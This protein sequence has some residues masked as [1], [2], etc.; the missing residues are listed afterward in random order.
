LLTDVIRK[1]GGTAHTPCGGKGVCR[2]CRVEVINEA[3]VLSCQY[4]VT[5][6]CHVVIP[7][8][9]PDTAVVQ[10]ESAILKDIAPDKTYI[11]SGLYGL[12]IDIG[13]TTVVVYLIELATGK[14]VDTF[15]FLNPQSEFGLDVI[16][17]I[18]YT[19]ENSDGLKT[20]QSRIVNAINTGIDQLSKRNSIP[21][22][23]IV[24][25]VIA[26]NTTMLHLLAGI[27][28]KGIAFAPFTPAFIEEKIIPAADIGIKTAS[29]SNIIL[30]PS[31][32]AYV[33][34]DITSGIAVTPMTESEK[35]SLF[36]DIGTNGEMAIGNRDGF[37]C[38]STAAGP[39]F[40]GARIECGMGGIAGAVSSYGKNGYETI[41]HL[42]PAGICGS[43]LIDIIAWLL[44]KG[45]ASP[46][47]LLEEPFIVVPAE[48]TSIGKPI[49]ITPRDVR[50]TQL[51]KAAIAAGIKVL[52]QQA[53][54]TFSD[55]ENIYLAG[56]FGSYIN[57]K[58]AVRI[59]LLPKELESKI[60]SV[61]NTAGAGAFLAAKNDLFRDNIKSVVRK[62]KYVELSGL[63][64]FNDAYIDEMIFP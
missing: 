12:A 37:I 50:E 43:G 47:G 34:A 30:L 51:A 54:A 17:R 23:K 27:D 9:E 22:A 7:Q 8:N 48:E 3:F 46:E 10:S 40:E 13:T 16:S 55:V 36:I 14:R 57:I 44:E 33:G 59:G 49:V 24:K 21:S 53:G 38:C 45:I 60:K 31:I 64:E 61:G 62:C 19:I 5:H 15:S 2:K 20:L 52:V 42:K 4:R 11:N 41:G 63:M 39:A 29:G 18:N 58:S 28:P 1:A 26:A 35:L 25:T 32:S 56:G 6:D